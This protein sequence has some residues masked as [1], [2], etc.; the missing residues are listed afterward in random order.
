MHLQR[1][2]SYCL[3]AHGQY[4]MQTTSENKMIAENGREKNF[5]ELEIKYFNVNS[6]I[7]MVIYLP[8]V[9]K[10]Y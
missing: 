6:L 8:N 4:Q 3:L 9:C 5:L 7:A 1:I 10:S 2:F